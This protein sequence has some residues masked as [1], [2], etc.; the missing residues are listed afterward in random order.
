M[1]QRVVVM[2]AGRKVEEA[3]VGALF[4]RPR[5]PYT[6]GL[7]HSIPRLGASGARRRLEEIRGIVPSMREAIPGC[8]FAP[9]CAYATDRCRSEYPPLEQKAEG[10]SGACWEAY[11]IGAAPSTPA[12]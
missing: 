6:Q 3:P 4:A 9:R 12:G 1:A 8:V 2:Y 11:R 5:H 7:L 10:H